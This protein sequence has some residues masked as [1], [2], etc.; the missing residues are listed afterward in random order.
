ME[1]PRGPG[2]ETKLKPCRITHGIYENGDN[3]QETDER[4]NVGQLDILDGERIW[5]V[6][7]LWTGL[8]ILIVDRQY[9]KECGT[10][11]RRQRATVANRINHKTTT[12][13]ENLI[14]PD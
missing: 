8:A 7:H 1:G 11:Q 12:E 13:C 10:D 2:R 3:F 9:S 5:S 14:M 6:S 4:Q